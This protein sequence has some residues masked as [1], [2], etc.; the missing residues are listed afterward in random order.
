MATSR[1]TR[2]TRVV[3]SST[4]DNLEININETWKLE[5]F[6]GEQFDLHLLSPEDLAIILQDLYDNDG[7]TIDEIETIINDLQRRT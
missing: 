4:F 7:Y 1:T 3:S 5:F 2:T 6:A